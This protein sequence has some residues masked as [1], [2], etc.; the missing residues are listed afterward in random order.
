MLV[1]IHLNNINVVHNL[2][3]L[4]LKTVFYYEFPELSGN[5][6]FHNKYILLVETHLYF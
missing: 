6:I 3:F 5:T 4:H 1:Y 2:F